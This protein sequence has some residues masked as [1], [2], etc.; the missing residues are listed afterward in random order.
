MTRRTIR[1]TRRALGRLDHIGA[2]IAQDNPEAAAR[3]ISRIVTAVDALAAHPAMGRAGRIRT[4]RE[5]V[6]ADS[7]Y[8][9]VYRV[10]E[11]HVDILTVIHAAQKWPD[12]L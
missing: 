4:T 1:W 6:L 11:N 3:V 8:I 2:Y 5:L 7:P 12:E 10:A 9:I